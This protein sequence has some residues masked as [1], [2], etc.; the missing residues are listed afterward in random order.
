MTETPENF[1][2]LL[3]MK[4][5][6]TWYE[7]SNLRGKLVLI[8]CDKHDNQYAHHTLF[9][10]APKEKTTQRLSITKESGVAVF[11]KFKYGY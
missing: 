2:E 11:D 4:V 9:S 6:V 3:K 1:G 8:L 10:S 7:P 5:Q